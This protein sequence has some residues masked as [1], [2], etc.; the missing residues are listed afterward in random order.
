MEAD[1]FKH[2]QI[3]VYLVV[4]S[5][6][7]VVLYDNAAVR[8]LRAV[9]LPIWHKIRGRRCALILLSLSRRSPIDML[10]PAISG[11][12]MVSFSLEARCI[13]I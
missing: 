2:T 9:G 3:G 6:T 10:S 12:Y 8:S 4:I 7:S 1:K 5:L 13:T 11:G